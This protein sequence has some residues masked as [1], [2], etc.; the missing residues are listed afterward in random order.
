MFQKINSSNAPKPV[1]SYSQALGIDKFVF[2]SGQVPLDPSSGVIVSGGIKEQTIQVFKNIEAVL[3][4][5]GLS[6]NNVIKCTVFLTDISKFAEFDAVY[7]QCF[8]AHAP[9]RSTVEVSKL[10]RGAAVEIES[11]AVRF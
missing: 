3:K 11:I 8:G 1:G 5:A 10:P 7:Q 4:E 2:L 9:A 6:L